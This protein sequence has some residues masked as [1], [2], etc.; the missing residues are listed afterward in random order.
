MID[1]ARRQERIAHCQAAMDADIAN[2]RLRYPGMPILILD[3]MDPDIPVADELTV[4]LQVPDDPDLQM[5]AQVLNRPIP[6]SR[7]LHFR[8]PPQ[9]PGGPNEQDRELLWYW[10]L[11][12][13]LAALPHDTAAVLR[14]GLRDRTY[15]TGTVLS[16]ALNSSPDALARN[17]SAF[18]IARVW[19]E[20]IFTRCV[21]LEVGRYGLS[22]DDVALHWLARLPRLSLPEVDSRKI[23]SADLLK[24][25]A[26]ESGQLIWAWNLWRLGLHHEKL[27]NADVA[28]C[29]R[30]RLC[31]FP[32]SPEE[33]LAI[34]RGN[35]RQL[36]STVEA[37]VGQ[38]H[39]PTVA[40]LPE[41][42]PE[43]LHRVLVQF[44]YESDYHPLTNP[45]GPLFQALKALPFD[46]A[47][48]QHLRWLAIQ[49]GVWPAAA[50]DSGDAAVLR[51]RFGKKKPGK[52]E[53]IGLD[54]IG[55]IALRDKA[56]QAVP[57]ELLSDVIRSTML[58]GFTDTAKQVAGFLDTLDPA[59]SALLAERVA[60]ALEA[61]IADKKAARY[62]LPLLAFALRT[63]SDRTL[64]L[65][66]AFLAKTRAGDDVT[67]AQLLDYLALTGQ[68]EALA[69]LFDI[70]EGHRRSVTMHRAGD[71]LTMIRRH[72]GESAKAL[73]A[74]AVPDWGFDAQGRLLLETGIELRLTP[75][76][77][78][79]IANGVQDSAAKARIA[80][81]QEN[82]QWV[83]PMLQR[84]ALSAMVLQYRWPVAEWHRLYRERPLWGALG[85]RVLWLWEGA[86]GAAL[87]FRPAEDGSYL[88][89]AGDVLPPLGEGQ[90]RFADEAALSPDAWAAWQ[91]H[92]QDFELAP[93]M[94][95]HPRSPAPGQ[96]E[97]EF[98]QRVAEKY[99]DRV[100]WS[101]PLE[102]MR[103]VP[104]S[105][106]AAALEP[107]GWR[108]ADVQQDGSY[109]LQRPIGPWF[110]GLGLRDAQGT[111]RYP[112]KPVTVAISRWRDG[113]DPSEAEVAR[114]THAA[115]CDMAAL[116]RE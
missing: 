16:L 62:Y 89:A 111:G 18:E 4:D 55:E 7:R 40:M 96:A 88:D 27:G 73:R 39:P 11:L 92:F 112:R 100:R 56:G 50:W 25:H 107:L 76:L 98:D 66:R 59:S 43:Q 109:S 85:Q 80:Q 53:Q 13:Q 38:N 61:H 8:L 12:R 17:H 90:V 1:E 26:R 103:V 113:A 71:S 115:L 14:Y 79:V 29:D 82:A 68:A 30:F 10:Q 102:E 32:L 9:P 54:A 28:I 3:P 49:W 52:T 93:L 86:D 22:N 77:E 91:Q 63:P 74:R 2:W 45:D 42:T 83:G 78:P 99:P 69:M 58:D 60:P 15:G 114:V 5:L 36:A 72:T 84:A 105:S 34:V 51:K 41:L 23:D 110:V 33:R 104:L 31:H 37:L 65:A 24:V 48:R 70:V 97:M 64:R 46:A 116:P 67:A 95:Q 47:Q 35:F 87:A 44:K 6:Q 81:L 108:K 94:V 101:A 57:P 19:S 75:M 21:W 106:I 20:D